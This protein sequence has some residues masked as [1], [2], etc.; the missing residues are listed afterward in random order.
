L[1]RLQIGAAALC[2]V[3]VVTAGAWL[4]MSGTLEGMA[5]RT[6]DGAYGAT[7]RAGFEVQAIYL[8]GRDR[9]PVAEVE[10]ALAVGRGDPILRLSLDDL[11]RRLESI[12][13]V[14]FAAVERE[15][16]GALHV[17]LLEREPVALWQR[18]GRV[19]PVDDMGVVMTDID[20]GN[21]R[22]LPLL[23]GEDAPEHVTEILSLL[24]LEPKL[25]ERFKAAVRVGGRR[26]NIRMDNGVEI[27]LPED[28][29]E[30][31][32]KKLSQIDA[33][34][35][36]L[37]RD[38]KVIDLRLQDRLFITVPPQDTPGKAVNAK[39]T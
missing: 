20:I 29:P 27:K 14:R 3:G 15:L 12:S 19:A 7:A 37:E 9:T 13:S 30:S 23:V 36:L 17:H 16:P 39:E 25:A 6:V 21:W 31:A 22:H 11:R 38:V 32:W 35:H 5:Q 34:Q 28:S 2:G 24:A 10:K 26:W 1:H 4:W 33:R 18:R 8:S